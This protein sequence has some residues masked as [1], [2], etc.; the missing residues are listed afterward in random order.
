MIEGN[1]VNDDSLLGRDVPT[2]NYRVFGD[3][4]NNSNVFSN[5]DTVELYGNT[6]LIG[7]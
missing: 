2:G 3:W 5:Q 7:G 4:I 6:Q 1:V